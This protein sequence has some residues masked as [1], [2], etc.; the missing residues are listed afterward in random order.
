MKVTNIIVYQ[1][2]LFYKKGERMTLS[3]GRV[4]K[5]LDATVVKILTNTEHIGWGESVPWGANYLPA[6]AKGVRSVIE[7]VAPKLIGQDPTNIGL[8]SSLMDDALVGHGY[9]KHAIEMACWDLLG[10]STQ[11]PL[12]TL[13]GGCQSTN[14]PVT[15]FIGTQ[16][17]ESLKSKLDAFRLDNI[18]QLSV[19]ASGDI[20]TDIQFIRHLSELLRSYETIRID[21]NGGWRIDEALRFTKACRDIDIVIEQPCQTYEECRNLRR[22]SNIPLILDECATGLDVLVR[23]QSDGVLDGVNIKLGRVGG[24]S[25]ARKMRDFCSE[26]NIPM[27]IQC[28][29]GSTITS[30][31]ITHLA[32]STPQNKL[33]SVWNPA[34]IIETESSINGPQVHQSRI[35]CSSRP[36]LGVTPIME[37]LGN[38]IAKY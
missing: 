34:S 1:L 32:H 36:G 2:N 8:I 12:Y 4:N 3:G 35:N 7:E 9:A 28:M 17:D 30:A 22:S 31:A 11:T 27:L 24:L 15:A 20:N 25:S 5:Y 18:T 21:A 38:P 6:F 37:V 13:L 33:L 14:M 19:K 29:G 26:F 23:A 10:K 16:V